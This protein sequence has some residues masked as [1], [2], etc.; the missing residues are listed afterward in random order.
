MNSV[1]KRKLK[2]HFD[3]RL[4]Q[5]FGLILT[6]SD[7]EDLCKKCEDRKFAALRGYSSQSGRQILHIHSYRGR[8]FTVIYDQ[9]YRKLVTCLNNENIRNSST[10]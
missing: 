7:Y 5:R 1:H 6:E 9:I 2:H 10:V 8:S 3:V 4:F